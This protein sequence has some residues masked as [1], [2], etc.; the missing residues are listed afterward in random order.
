MRPSVVK[1]ANSIDKMEQKNNAFNQYIS[2]ASFLLK[3]VIRPAI[4]AGQN[5]HLTTPMGLVLGK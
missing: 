5:H 1:V 2:G 4:R 3:C